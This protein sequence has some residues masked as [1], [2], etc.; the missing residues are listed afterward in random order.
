[1]CVEVA[2]RTR[3]RVASMRPWLS[4]SP[5]TRTSSPTESAVPPRVMVEVPTSMVWL[6]PSRVCIVIVGR[7]SVVTVPTAPCALDMNPCGSSKPPGK[8]GGRKPRPASWRPKGL[9]WLPYTTPAWKMSAARKSTPTTPAT[10]RTVRD[11]KNIFIFSMVVDY[12]GNAMSGNA[13]RASFRACRSDHT[14]AMPVTA[15]SKS[16]KEGSESVSE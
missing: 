7:A 1:M 12:A 16:A 5:S 4:G 10:T 14:S 3:I 11:T 15:R 8:N 13:N 2:D 9:R 6:V